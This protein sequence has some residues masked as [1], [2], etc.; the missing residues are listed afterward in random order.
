MNVDR[1]CF[2]VCDFLMCTRVSH[3]EFELEVCGANRIHK[4]CSCMPSETSG[5]P[6][7]SVACIAL[8][9]RLHSSQSA[10]ASRRGAIANHLFALFVI[11]ALPDWNRK[12]HPH[13]RKLVESAASI[14]LNLVRSISTSHRS[15]VQV[16]S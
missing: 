12:I 13:A 6:I 15:L 7:G 2:W 4:T 3:T 10:M 9:V 5:V 8:H 14:L 16:A 11:L 1:D